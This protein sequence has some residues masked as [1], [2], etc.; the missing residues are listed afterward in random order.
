[1]KILII[2]S[3]GNMGRR[4]VA[5]CKYLGHEV[6]ECDLHN[7]KD[8]YDMPPQVDRAI[9]A[10]PINQHYMWCEY[11]IYNKI[12]F[13]CEKPISKNIEEI[14]ELIR[15]S[16]ENHVNGRMVC[17]WKFVV[18]GIPLTQGNND[19]YFNY[20]NTGKDGFWDLIQPVYLSRKFIFKNKSPYYQC[21]IGMVPA[22]QYDFDWAYFIMIDKWLQNDKYIWSLPQALE[23]TEK[24]IAWAKDNYHE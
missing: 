2:G 7:I 22:N 4:Y 21:L 12:P 19:I 6:I 24:L 15:L 11:C 3:K 17:N 5:I 10:T 23:A 8:I 18:R 16:E 20:Y 9:I 13:L 1:M 14:K